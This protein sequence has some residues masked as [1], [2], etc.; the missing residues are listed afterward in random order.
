MGEKK[1]KV[2]ESVWTRK[3]P[4]SEIMKK[5]QGQGR[6]NRGKESEKSVRTGKEQKAGESNK[7]VARGREKKR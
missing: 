3:K 7:S 1:P 5:Y 6:E 2:K 4:T